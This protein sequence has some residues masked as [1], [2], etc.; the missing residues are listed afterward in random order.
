MDLS[1]AAFH[2]ARG[3]SRAA[4]IKGAVADRRVGIR[5]VI[6][7]GVNKMEQRAALLSTVAG[8][9][10]AVLNGQRLH[11]G[12]DAA[13][14]IFIRVFQGLAVIEVGILYSQVAVRRTGLGR[15][16]FDEHA[17]AILGLAVVEVAVVDLH[18]P[19]VGINGAML[20]VFA[21]EILAV[22]DQVLHPK[23]VGIVV[24]CQSTGRRFDKGTF[25]AR[26]A[27]DGGAGICNGVDVVG[28][29]GGKRM[30]GI[31]PEVAV[32]GGLE[33]DVARRS[34]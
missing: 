29:T 18:I 34:S 23:H 25:V 9:K 19:T 14:A 6:R 5:R 10:V 21:A 17:A 13:A 31:I 26:A 11:T 4:A 15:D 7:S 20:D 8:G 33:G 3:L 30:I 12:P 27:A 16:G 2:R 22:E 32:H 24:V 1:R 28:R